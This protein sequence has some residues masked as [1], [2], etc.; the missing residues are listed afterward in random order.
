[1]SIRNVLLI[2][3][4]TVAVS[5]ASTLI[6]MRLTQN[7]TNE[8][9][10]MQISLQPQVAVTSSAPVQ[11]VPA[12]K[13]PI[14]P[15]PAPSPAPAATAAPSA[16]STLAALQ[17]PEA[18]KAK[19]DNRKLLKPDDAKRMLLKRTPA[20]EGDYD[21][22]CTENQFLIEHPLA[23]L[24]SNKDKISRACL[25]QVQ[26]VQQ[27]FR[28]ACDTDIRRFCADENNYFS[29]L[30]RKI[31]ELTPECQKNIKESSRQ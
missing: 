11:M 18:F 19:S 21:E 30:K 22:F 4:G 12:N 14:P 8:V 2:I 1:M 25:N 31:A 13:Q 15:P 5:V 17:Q 26:G 7:K 10:P 9:A 28:K 27:A 16:L 6:T 23:C 24:R 3:F 29:C 20:C